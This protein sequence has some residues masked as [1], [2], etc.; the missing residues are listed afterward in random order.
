MFLNKKYFIFCFKHDT[1]P[2]ETV[3]LEVKFKRLALILESTIIFN[4]VQ[5]F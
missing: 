1:V 5:I 4:F 3:K 2:L